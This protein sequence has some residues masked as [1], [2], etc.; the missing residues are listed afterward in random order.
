MPL[1][2]VNP[3][4]GELV[5][6][7]AEASAEEVS[8]VLDSAARA[9]ESWRHAVRRASGGAAPRRGAAARAPRASSPG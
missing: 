7:Y 6:E 4:S 5:R 3:A 9:F 2:S 1:Q 8:A